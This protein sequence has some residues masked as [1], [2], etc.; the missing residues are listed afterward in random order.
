MPDKVIKSD[1]GRRPPLLS[2][3]DNDAER[4]AFFAYLDE[5]NARTPVEAAQAEQQRLSYYFEALDK[6]LTRGGPAAKGGSAR[7]FS[8]I[9]YLIPPILRDYKPRDVYQS[10]DLRGIFKEI[11]AQT[12]SFVLSEV[13]ICPASIAADPALHARPHVHMGGAEETSLNAYENDRRSY[14][15]G[16]FD[17]RH[18]SLPEEIHWQKYASDIA[19]PV[20]FLNDDM[21]NAIQPYQ[22]QKLLQP[23]QDIITLC[24]HDMMHNMVNTIS[25][26]DISR[27]LEAHFKPEMMHFMEHKIGSYGAEDTLGFESA[28]IVGHARTW[29]D[30]KDTPIGEKMSQAVDRFY[31]HLQAMAAG[32]EKDLSP[33]LE[34]RRQTL[35]YFAMA[36]PYALTRLVS[37]HDPLM[38][39]ALQ[40][41]ER[42][43]SAFNHA[44][45]FSPLPAPKTD[46]PRFAQ[47]LQNYRKSGTPL[48]ADENNPQTYS[49]G[50]KLQLAGMLPGIA[51]LLSPA[52]KGSPEYK[53]H[54]RADEMDRDI[55]N[56]II[57][58][59]KGS[60]S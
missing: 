51:L 25:R 52:R 50:K 36:V 27:P 30:L 43:N 29:L 44:P 41:A 47:T 15:F 6:R 5:Q 60:P 59:A 39:R 48:A 2:A 23:L 45:P 38:A 56:I 8:V 9:T 22:P 53:A 33:G 46:D 17:V 12:R 37:L 42:V 35:D 14:S 32:M 10:G 34:S 21:L 18:D 16:F 1:A 28:L 7:P 31:D 19:L 24:N 40:R 57:G 13:M 3:A 4:Q 55:V 20:L 49:E 58:H 11:A 54:S 26:G